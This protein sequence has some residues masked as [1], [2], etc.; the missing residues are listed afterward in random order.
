MKKTGF[1]ISRANAAE[2]ATQSRAAL[3]QRLHEG[4]ENMPPFPHLREA[5]VRSLIAYL[6]QLAGVPGAERE[7]IGVQE[8]SAQ[9]GEH[10]AKST[11]HTCHSAVGPNPGPQQLLDGAIPPLETLTIR[12]TQAEFVRKVTHGATILMGTPALLCRGRMPVFDYLSEQEAAAVYRYLTLYPPSHDAETRPAKAVAIAMTSNDSGG[13]GAGSGGGGTPLPQLASGTLVQP[14]PSERND[15]FS[16]TLVLSGIAMFVIGAIGAGLIVTVREFKRLGAA[17]Q[18]RRL[19][20]TSRPLFSLSP[21]RDME[22][23]G[24]S[25][26]VTGSVHAG[27]ANAT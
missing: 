22:A 16:T 15:T 5:E 26:G 8:S 6:K 7:Q 23:K 25:A 11:C 14:P 17:S 13:P 20:L 9:I 10:I 24:R 21:L 19:P 2:M 18:H 1:E 27:S 12:T 4:G 3:L